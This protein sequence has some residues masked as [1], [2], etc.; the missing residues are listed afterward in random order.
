M[1]RNVSNLECRGGPRILLKPGHIVRQLKKSPLACCVEVVEC[2]F[3]SFGRLG[4]RLV[5]REL[6]AGVNV[7]AVAPDVHLRCV[8]LRSPPPCCVEVLVSALIVRATWSS[9]RV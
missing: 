2:R 1:R 5:G 3:W 8:A 9:T 6:G 7:G 4:R